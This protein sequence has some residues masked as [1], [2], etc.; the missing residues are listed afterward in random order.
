MKKQIKSG[1]FLE[2]VSISISL[3]SGKVDS[4]DLAKLLQALRPLIVNLLDTEVEI[5]SFEKKETD[6]PEK[7]LSSVKLELHI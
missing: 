4:G 5:L 7:K 2:D 6:F 1:D 3:R